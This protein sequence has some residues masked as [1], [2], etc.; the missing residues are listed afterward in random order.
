MFRFARHSFL[1]GFYVF[2]FCQK[3]ISF[4][5]VSPRKIP[6]LYKLYE[7]VSLLVVSFSLCLVDEYCYSIH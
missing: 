5:V 7:M 1:E 3:G 4:S 2:C 6:T